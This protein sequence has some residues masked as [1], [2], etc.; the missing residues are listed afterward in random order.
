[1]SKTCTLTIVGS[2]DDESYRRDL[3]DYGDA[4]NVYFDL[5]MLSDYDL[6]SYLNDCDFVVQNYHCTLNS[7]ITLLALSKNRPVL[8]LKNDSF[9]FLI[10]NGINGFKYEDFST[11]E[12]EISNLIKNKD[13]LKKKSF[14]SVEKYDCVRLSKLRDKLKL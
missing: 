9:D 8:C 13:K 5:R 12:S 10:E 1:M 4:D 11:L 2:V 3:L 7:G 14:K 6:A